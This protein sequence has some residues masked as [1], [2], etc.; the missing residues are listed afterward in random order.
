MK[1]ENYNKII[2]KFILIKMKYPK[3]DIYRN[4]SLSK[5]EILCFVVRNRIN[6]NLNGMIY[7]GYY[8]YLGCLNYE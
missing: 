8:I 2:D 6:E 7:Y 5:T 3:Y 4:F 1:K